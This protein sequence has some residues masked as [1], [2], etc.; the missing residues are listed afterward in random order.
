MR[1]IMD[2]FADRRVEEITIKASTQVGKSEAILNCMG[3]AIDQDPGPT[4]YVGPKE[5]EAK[6]FN[7]TR[8][9]PMI[10]LSEALSRHLTAYDD[11]VTREMIELD[12]MDVYVAWAGSPSSLASTPIRYLF[13]DEVNKYPAFSGEEANPIKLAWERTKTFWN[14]TVVKV[15][16]PTVEDGYITQEY[17]KS[18]QRQYYVPCPHCGAYQV[19]TFSQLRWPADVG[20]PEIVAHQMAWYECVACGRKIHEQHKIMMIQRGVWCPKG[21]TVGESGVIEGSI[22]VTRH[23]G[24]CINT[25]YAPWINTSFSHVAAEFLEAKENPADLMNFVNSWLAEEWK[26]KVEERDPDKLRRFVRPDLPQS[27]VPY[28]AAVLT[29]GIDTQKDYYKYVVKA[30]GLD[31]ESWTIECGRAD[32]DEELLNKVCRRTF[33][34]EDDRIDPMYIRLGCMDSGG[35]KSESGDSRTNEVYEFCRHVRGLIVPTK[36]VDRLSGNIYTPTKIDKFTSG[37]PIPAGLILYRFDTNFKKDQLA[38]LMDPER[39]KFHICDGMPDSYFNEMCA[40]VKMKMLDKKRRHGKVTY[41][42]QKKTAASVNDYWDC[43]VLALLAARMAMV[44]ALK[45]EDLPSPLPKASKPGGGGFIQADQNFL[46]R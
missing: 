37:V 46:R 10:Q 2:V 33:A 11:D 18:D 26:E 45:K 6:K 23:R 22:P 40:E 19:L 29:A 32:T 42:W 7:K 1:E 12:R 5:N 38:G 8:I 31:W 24:Y 13:L 20:G 36:G 3:Y 35:T 17:E 9:Q 43:E 21:C 30:W 41:T 25:L 39:N 27:V 14:R 4:L 15:S 28:G 44:Y 34:H 16:T